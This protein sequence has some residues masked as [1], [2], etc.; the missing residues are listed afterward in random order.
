MADQFTPSEEITSDDKLWALLAYIVAI[1]VPIIILVMEDKKNR[2][3]LRYHAIQALASQIVL[4]IITAV[5]CGF[6][7]VVFLVEIY[8]AIKAY[9]GEYLVIPLL[10]D[11]MK[12][13]GWVS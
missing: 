7:S 11:F 2:R 10:T 3:F 1:I 6:G 5:T 9:Q 12:K 13:Q 4:S 8:F